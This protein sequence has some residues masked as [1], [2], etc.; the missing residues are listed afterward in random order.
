MEDHFYLWRDRNYE[1]LVRALI[2]QFVVDSVTVC[3]DNIPYKSILSILR[4]VV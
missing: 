3:F 2:P 1:F 4:S